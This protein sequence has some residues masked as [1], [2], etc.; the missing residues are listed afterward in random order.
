M[1]PQNTGCIPKL[2]FK[3]NIGVCLFC[4]YNILHI[5]YLSSNLISGVFCNYIMLFISKCGTKIC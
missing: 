1:S 3:S 4:H 5:K 2:F